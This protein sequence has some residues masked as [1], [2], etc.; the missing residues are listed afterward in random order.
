ML[1]IASVYPSGGT[2]S[3]YYKD[4]GSIDPDDT[5]DLR[6][7]ADAG[8]QIDGPGAIIEYTMAAYVLPPGTT[9]N[10]G[11]TYFDRLINPLEVS[12]APSTIL[13]YLPLIMED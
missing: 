1:A 12:V 11:V 8:L 6:S 9:A 13:T 4:E 5:G 7:Y 3:N 2:L 10:V